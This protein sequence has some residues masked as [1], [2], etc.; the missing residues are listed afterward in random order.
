MGCMILEL[1]TG[2]PPF[3]GLLSSPARHVREILSTI[4]GKIPEQWQQ[5]AKKRNIPLQVWEDSDNE[6][7]IQAQFQEY[8]P[9][10]ES[11]STEDAWKMGELVEKMLVLGTAARASAREILADPWFANVR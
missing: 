5:K 10:H 1:A 9:R 3:E 11:W 7:T 2:H 8:C 6:Y 4:G